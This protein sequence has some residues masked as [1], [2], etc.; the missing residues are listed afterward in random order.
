ML[1]P[2]ARAPAGRLFCCYNSPKSLGPLFGASL[3]SIAPGT[4]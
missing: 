1:D 4:V 2:Q 3:Y